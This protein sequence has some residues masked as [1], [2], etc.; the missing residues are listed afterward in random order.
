MLE[1]MFYRLLA[2]FQKRRAPYVLVGG[3][4]GLL[5]LVNSFYD[6]M[7]SSPEAK[8]TRDLHPEDMSEARKR[9]YM[10]L[11]GWF[12]GPNLYWKAYGHPRMRARHMKFAIGPVERDQWIWCMQ[13]AVDSRPFHPEF[14]AYIMKS[15]IDFA[16]HMQNRKG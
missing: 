7:E 11:S 15:F 5:A 2:T 13:K 12:G 6:I 16:H 3:K 4:K 9:L 1:L 14:K 8:Q 10:F